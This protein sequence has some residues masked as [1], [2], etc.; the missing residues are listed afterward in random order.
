LTVR[1][2]VPDVAIL[3]LDHRIRQAATQLGL[4]M[5]PTDAE[6]RS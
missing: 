3:T 6:L 4:P 1:K 5:V 2:A